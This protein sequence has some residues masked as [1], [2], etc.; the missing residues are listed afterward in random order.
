M[1]ESIYT[2]VKENKIINEWLYRHYLTAKLK[3]AGINAEREIRSESNK[4][5]IIDDGLKH[6]CSELNKVNNALQQIRILRIKEQQ[7]KEGTT[8][9]V[10]VSFIF[11]GLI[12]YALL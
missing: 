12:I 3:S 1:S 10:V 4:D 9:L 7:V 8:W 2:L 11:L 6:Y 5:V